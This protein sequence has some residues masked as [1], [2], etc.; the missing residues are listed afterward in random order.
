VKG[1]PAAL[2]RP[3]VTGDSPA[4]AELDHRVNPSPWS[5]AQ[6]AELCVPAPERHEWMLVAE[7]DGRL[8][9]FVVYSLV[10]DEACI[11][12]IAVDP[13][14]QRGGLGG[15][16][17]AAALRQLRTDGA[18][19]CYLE[20]R[21]SNTAAQ[22]LYEKHGFTRAGLRRNYYP[23]AAGREDAVLMSRPLGQE[24]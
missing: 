10:L 16:L 18:C 6:F 2:V 12:N 9:G 17:L 15:L 14:A 7:R 8:R 13:E 1:E 22:A 3:A 24:E 20:V 11:H 19:S 23:A 5:Q 4:L 21:A